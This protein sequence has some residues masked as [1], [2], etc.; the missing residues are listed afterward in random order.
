MTDAH[1][2]S[3]HKSSNLQDETRPDATRSSRW[4]L[5]PLLV[6]LLLPLQTIDVQSQQEQYTVPADA[7]E[8][9][10]QL[11]CFFTTSI[12]TF[13]APKLGLLFVVVP[14]ASVVP[15]LVTVP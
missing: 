12:T 8:A 11:Y 5:T 3:R 2:S 6:T 10:P 9:L 13:A 7:H 15:A 4:C 14:Y 1:R